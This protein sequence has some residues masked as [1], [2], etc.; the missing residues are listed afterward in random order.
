MGLRTLEIVLGVKLTQHPGLA[1]CFSIVSL[2]FYFME[3]GSALVKALLYCLGVFEI[4]QKDNVF[5]TTRCS[6]TD[7]PRDSSVFRKYSNTAAAER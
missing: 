2:V 4:K 5:P 1:W 7:V 6:T 3:F